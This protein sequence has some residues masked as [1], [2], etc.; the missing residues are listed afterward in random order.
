[1]NLI[2]GKTKNVVIFLLILLSAYF[3][4]S[5]NIFNVA[6]N[7]WFEKHQYDS[8]QL[9]LDGLLNGAAS[10]NEV[11]LGRYTRPDVVN[12]YLLTRE[13]Y[14]EG[15]KSGKFDWYKSQFG[16]QVKSFAILSRIG[17][18]NASTLQSIAAL[19]MSLVVVAMFGFIWRDFSLLPA[20]IFTSVYIFSPWVVVFSRN[21]YWVSFTWFLPLLTT[22][23]L[24][25]K[26]YAYKDQM[27][28]M[29]G[30]LFFA[31][32]LKL[33]RGYEYVTTIFFASCVP[34]F[35]QGV[36]MGL[37]LRLIFRKVFM[38]L[39]VPCH[40]YVFSVGNSMKIKNVF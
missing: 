15:N 2:S 9:V 20:L 12:Q 32:L 6:S 35:Y 27:Y 13:L 36:R 7:D 17:L 8:E 24:A 28:L 19:L 40:V 34:I 21:L 37:G 4:Y 38:P 14:A 18:S 23:W 22:M 11:V 1:M 33:L 16:L 10:N 39:E 29:S 26:I 31:Y 30:A 25:P 5:I 3:S